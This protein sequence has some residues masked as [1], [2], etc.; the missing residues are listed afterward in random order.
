M[1]NT[2][3]LYKETTDIEL[4]NNDRAIRETEEQGDIESRQVGVIFL[5]PLGSL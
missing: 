1:F 2:Y 4:E 3:D 5:N